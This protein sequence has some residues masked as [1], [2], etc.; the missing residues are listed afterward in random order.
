M[1]PTLAPI[2]WSARPAT[3]RS[4]RFVDWTVREPPLRVSALPPV[5]GV[6]AVLVRWFVNLFHERILFWGAHPFYARP[7]KELV[8][9]RVPARVSGVEEQAVLVLVADVALQVV[10]GPGRDRDKATAAKKA[11]HLRR[12]VPHT[13]HVSGLLTFHGISFARRW[14][15]QQGTARS[16][17]RPA[18]HAAALRVSVGRRST[19]G[20][21]VQQEIA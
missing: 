18:R 20:H 2:V 11:R 1:L 10:A 7:G 16:G 21:P 17:Q 3:G 15:T 14:G 12:L 6:R 13:I 4:G 5:R 8:S 19:R 9:G